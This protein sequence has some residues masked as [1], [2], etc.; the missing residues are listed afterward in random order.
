MLTAEDLKVLS[1]PFESSSHYFLNGLPY[2]REDAI[3]DRIEQVDPAW[4]LELISCVTRDDTVTAI[5]RLTVKGV[6]RDGVGMDSVLRSK[7]SGNEVNEAEKSAVTDALKRA[8][9]LFSVGRY[10]LSIPKSIKNE[11]QLATYLGGGSQ[12]P[13]GDNNQSQIIES[14]L[15]RI[16]IKQTNEGRPYMIA[17]DT[18]KRTV[19]IWTRQP[20]IDAGWITLEDWLDADT[21]IALENAIP[22]K[23]KPNPNGKGFLI[24]EVKPKS[25]IPF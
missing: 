2:I 1:A 3:C 8:A 10:L 22:V 7:S 19:S 23:L 6:T 5:V 9:R 20:F 24:E 4:G 17:H 11:Q 12:P 13:Q 21:K 18:K 25:V 16:E 15:V 14:E